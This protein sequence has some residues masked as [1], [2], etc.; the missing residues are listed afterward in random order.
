MRALLGLIFGVLVGGIIGYSQILC[1]GGTC[2]LT[3]TWL[4]G[5]AIGGLLGHLLL[6]G[7]TA[8][9]G[10]SCCPAEPNRSAPSVDDDRRN[11]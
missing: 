7:R 5:A 6:G 2:P 10:Q 11:P 1:F 4:G 9:A 3:G 8:C